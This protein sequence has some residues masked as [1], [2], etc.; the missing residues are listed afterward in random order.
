MMYYLTTSVC[1]ISEKVIIP[2]RE[3]KRTPQKL[4]NVL[5]SFFS[6]GN[7]FLNDINIRAKLWCFVLSIFFI[8]LSWIMERVK[9]I[10][11]DKKHSIAVTRM[12]TINNLLYSI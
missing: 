5:I 6:Q 12:D 11:L 1:C 8:D 3:E 9:Q 7:V 2:I 10:I 4:R